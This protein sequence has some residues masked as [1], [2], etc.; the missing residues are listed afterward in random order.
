MFN[1]QLADKIVKYLNTAFPDKVQFDDL[2]KGLPEFAAQPEGEWLKALEALEREGRAEFKGLR[3]GHGNT[4]QMVANIVISNAERRRLA[5]MPT[6]EDTPPLVAPADPDKAR[7]VWVVHG[8][9]SRTKSAMFTFLLALGLK[10]LSFGKARE[11][12]GKA[13]PHISEI[14]KAAF[15][16]AQAVVVLLTPD[17]EGRL[18]PDFL[19]G[20][21]QPSDTQLTPQPRLNVI[22]EAGMAV[23]SHPEQTI[24]VT[25]GYIRPFSD[26]SGLHYVLMDGTVEQR[27][28]LALRLGAA[29]CPV[30]LE[31][32]HWLRAGDF[33]PAGGPNKA[34]HE[35]S[36]GPLRSEVT[37]YVASLQMEWE[38]QKK[39]RPVLLGP[40][41]KIVDR[42]CPQLL[43]LH[44]KALTQGAHTLAAKL[45]EAYQALTKYEGAEELATLDFDDAAFI[46]DIDAAIVLLKS[47]VSTGAK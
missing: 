22:F 9:D 8:R 7:H 12:T 36:N 6:G 39:K 25:L 26:V 11:F 17:D 40:L 20:D 28:E 15:Q 33:A 27:R 41:W 1:R 43:E 3:T 16:H 10:P 45:S 38:S 42:A 4:L 44:T 13:M 47:G 37:A 29:G 5:A 34:A 18:R 32:E 14:L 46:A 21:D 31:D 2:R 35:P 30:S 24:F 19:K 23:V